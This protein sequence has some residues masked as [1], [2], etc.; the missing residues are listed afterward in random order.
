[1]KS[2]LL[3]FFLAAILVAPLAAE[4]SP[5]PVTTAEQAR[6]FEQDL[7]LLQC[8]IDASVRL[9]D[10][11]DP[12]RRAQD[13]EALGEKLA[14]ALTEAV[15][16]SDRDR[17]SELSEHLYAVLTQGLTPN[18][19]TLASQVP[20]GST[21][22]REMQALALRM[23]QDL[24]R[25]EERLEKENSRVGTPTVEQATRL[26]REARSQMLRESRS[27]TP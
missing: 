5:I 16:K 11:E 10:T 7:P 22:A 12:F 3:L 1:M 4:D 2:R 23:Q 21:P 8:L 26:V 25:L 15:E 13:C 6:R 17:I 14:A 20:A 18:L 27:L 19:R 9:A 24:E